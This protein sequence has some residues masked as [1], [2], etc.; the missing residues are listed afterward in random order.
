[1][2][3]TRLLVG[4]AAAAIVVAAYSYFLSP[5]NPAS[6]IG[7]GEDA[8]YTN[9]MYGYSFKYGNKYN[10]NEYTPEYVSIG[11]KTADGFDSLLDVEV[12]QSNAETGESFD[13][14]THQHAENL[15]AADGPRES[16]RCTGVSSSEPY[17]ASTGTAGE[18]FYLTQV[19]MQLPSNATSSEIRGPFY[20]FNISANMPSK[21]Y[22]A[23][24][25][26]PAIA[27]PQSEVKKDLIN[28]IADTIQINKVETR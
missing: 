24:L 27:Q 18:R 28:S 5:K 12:A 7:G 21:K 11:Q 3:T 15:C 20:S 26:H 10:L 1:M 23:V 6:P 8:T 17:S 2:N 16:I 4:V 19:T 14:F 13:D 22:T 25:I 9:K